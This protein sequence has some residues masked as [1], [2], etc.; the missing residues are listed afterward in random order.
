MSQRV[1]KVMRD[2]QN[3]VRE[4]NLLSQE[5]ASFVGM[6]DA[7]VIEA[8]A[9]HQPEGERVQSTQNHDRMEKIALDYLEKLERTNRQWLMCLRQRY[10]VLGDE[11]R[12]IE[13]AVRSLPDGL[14]GIMWDIL[15]GEMTWEDIADKHM[16]SRSTIG[17]KRKKAIEILDRLYYDRDKLYT[18]YVVG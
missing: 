11:I 8:M 14:S 13:N 18:A 17:Y 10:Q 15:L 9:F 16:M 2:Y 12:F 6:T 1:S 4:R 3:M 5:I 7:D